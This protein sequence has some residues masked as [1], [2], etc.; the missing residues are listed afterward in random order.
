MNK[1]YKKIEDSNR[2]LFLIGVEPIYVIALAKKERKIKSKSALG[3]DYGKTG[4]S[5]KIDLYDAADLIKSG[6]SFREKDP[7]YVSK[8]WNITKYSYYPDND[9][10]AER[11]LDL[12]DL[13]ALSRA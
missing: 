12:G 13:E 2:E 7:D 8:N 4:D 5:F 6:I 11:P 3:Y 1:L 9:Y 10:R